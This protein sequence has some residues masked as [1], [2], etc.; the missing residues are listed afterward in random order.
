MPDNFHI[1]FPWAL[2]LLP[3]PLLVYW[4]LPSLRMRSAALLLP[5]Y[6]KAVEYTDQKPRKSAFVKK[7]GLFSWLIM[8]VIWC[9]LVAAMTNP[10]LVGKPEMKIKTS[11]NF[12]IVADISFSMAKTD[13]KIDGKKSRRWDAVKDVMHDFIQKRKGDRMGLV[14]FGTNAYIQAPFTPDLLTVGQM[15]DEADVGMAGQMTHIGK[16]INKGLEMFDNDTLK[17][18]VMLLLTDGIDAGDGIQP[19]DAAD[20]ARKDSVMIYTLGIGTP[21]HGGSDLDERTLE[22][23]AELTGGQ[24]FLAKDENRLKE[25]Y[26]ELDKLEP[27]E[28]EETQNKPVTM[29]YPYPLAVAMALA[30]LSTM[31]SVFVSAIKVFRERKEANYA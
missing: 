4:L 29:L 13:W 6:H 24:Y 19:L 3:L 23:I 17:T 8:F 1:A 21:G 20:R 26:S 27:M 16:A 12:L 10:Q 30:I 22:Q 5:N 28:Y 25:I 7:R 14:F 11:R 2:A 9:L 18:K 31:L 15:L